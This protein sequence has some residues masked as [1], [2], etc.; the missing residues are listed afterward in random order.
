MSKSEIKSETQSEQ[1]A[2]PSETE[3][4]AEQIGAQ[5][6]VELS[7]DSA[8]SQEFEYSHLASYQGESAELDQ[9]QPDTTETVEAE[10]LTDED[11]I[12]VTAL[13]VEQIANFVESSFDTP[14][15]ID[16]DTREVITERALPVIKKHCKGGKMPAWLAKYQEEFQLGLVLATTAV[17]II[18]Q[19][20]K[21]EKQSEISSEKQ[22]VQVGS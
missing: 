3:M 1:T 20:R 9:A 18:S 16:N 19:V 12:G 13:G 5:S 2:N 6:D 21:G 8:P 15:T 14:V 11:M 10:A 7:Q 4:T 22:G 17:S